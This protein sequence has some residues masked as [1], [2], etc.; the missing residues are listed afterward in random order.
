MTKVAPGQE[1]AG[2]GT[3][4][5]AQLITAIP[6]LRAFAVSLSGSLDRADDLVQETLVKAWSKF[7]SFKEGTNLEAWLFTI[8]RNVYYTEYRKRRREVSDSE[9][10]FAAKVACLPDQE[11]HMEFL[12][13]RQALQQ[14]PADQ[15]EALILIGASGF[16]YEEVAEICNCAIGTVKS[17]VSRARNRLSQLLQLETQGDAPTASWRESIL[18]SA[19]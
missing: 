10:T 2:R 17:R 12:D 8:L 15:R 11:H 14:L 4:Q 9:G 1:A 13:F 18:A 7:D 3:S 5:K 16:S 19:A 6:S